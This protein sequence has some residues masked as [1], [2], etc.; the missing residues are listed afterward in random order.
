M[1][2]FTA[3]RHIP[4]H[5]PY[6]AKLVIEAMDD[7][8]RTKETALL[9]NEVFNSDATINKKITAGYLR[10]KIFKRYNRFLELVNTYYDDELPKN[11]QDDALIRLKQLVS[12][13]QEFSAFIRWVVKEDVKLNAVLAQHLD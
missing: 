2:V 3:L 12:K 7:D 8:P 13:T 11:M 1:D 10:K 6:Q 5:T 9:L 4:P